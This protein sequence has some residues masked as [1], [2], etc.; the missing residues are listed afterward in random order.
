MT[1]TVG[2]F[3][4]T[5]R[6]QKCAKYGSIDCILLLIRKINCACEIK[7]GGDRL[8]NEGAANLMELRKRIDTTKMKAPSFEMVLTAIGDYAYRRT[9]GVLVVPIGCLKD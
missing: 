6:K 8:I 9:D 7:L 5:F 1:L 3:S 4:F 2:V